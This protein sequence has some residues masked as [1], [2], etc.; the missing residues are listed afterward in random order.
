MMYESDDGMFDDIGVGPAT[1][2]VAE[3]GDVLFKHHMICHTS[4]TNVRWPGPR[5]GSDRPTPTTHINSIQN[6]TPFKAQAPQNKQTNKQTKHAAKPR[7]CS[8]PGLH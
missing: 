7:S 1:E 5:H 3:A 2:F 4:S 8:K 6:G